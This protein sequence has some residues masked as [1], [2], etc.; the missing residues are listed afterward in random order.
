MAVS[1]V[2]RCDVCG[3]ELTGADDHFAYEEEG[4]QFVV[5]SLRLGNWNARTKTWDSIVSAYDICRSCGKQLTQA[6]FNVNE[7]TN[8]LK[9]RKKT[10]TPVKEEKKGE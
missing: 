5:N 8:N 10:F 1:V 9:S 6:I 4:E 3:K 7:G 2:K